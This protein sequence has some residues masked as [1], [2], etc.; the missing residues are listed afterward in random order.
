MTIVCVELPSQDSSG[1]GARDNVPFDLA[2]MMTW[3]E[4]AGLVRRE[5]WT[6]LDQNTADYGGDA[7]VTGAVVATQAPVVI[8]RLLDY[9]LERSLWLAKRLRSLM[10][11]THFVACGPE[12]TRDS[13]L[14]KSHAFDALIE[15]EPETALAGV[16]A[17]TATRSL[18]P[19]YRGEPVDA[20]T[21]PDPYLS[22]AL[23]MHPRKPVILRTSRGV[24]RLPSFASPHARGA[25]GQRF[26]HR[27]RGPKVLRMASDA[28]VAEAMFVDD[29]LD[30]H[31]EFAGY[32]KMLAAANESGVGLRA[33]I[34]PARIDD[35]TARLMADAAFMEAGGWL[36]STNARAQEAAG[37]SLDRDAFER[38][39]RL[40]WN[41]GIMVRPSV[42]IGLPFDDYDAVIETFDF[43]GMAGIGQDAE[44]KPLSLAPGSAMRLQPASYGIKD[45]VDRPPYYVLETEWMTEDDFVDAMADFEEN[46]DVAWTPPVA[47]VFKRE[48][49]GFIAFADLRDPAGL[50]RLLIDADKLAS[51]VTLLIDADNPELQKRIARS[52]TGLRKENPYTL[53][54]IVLVS[55]VSIPSPGSVARLADAFSMPDHYFGAARMFSVD[56]Q[57]DYQTRTFFATTSEALALA[58]LRERQDLETVFVLG[59]ELPG[60]RLLEAIP[61]LAFDRE[62]VP[63][64]LLYDVMSAYRSY[65]ELLVEAP[66]SILAP[67]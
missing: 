61:F 22:G 13:L 45:F 58:A 2:A 27:D 47:P 54:Q 33:R 59:Q 50:D 29:R 42:I 43:L 32:V 9:N 44:P 26:M 6:L 64:E 5:D 14:Q 21:M 62:A 48:R 46:F 31:P 63:F 7:A 66:R 49:G 25:P 37:M 23:T 3:A 60:Q 4:T 34:D 35:D 57:P 65:P 30:T 10:P 55:S 12:V 24:D 40:L 39:A 36:G 38:G 20:A 1:E 16:L 15:G 67:D 18:K 8:F 53:W 41:T 17:D 19:W 28:G 52:A 56:P 51:S 11:A